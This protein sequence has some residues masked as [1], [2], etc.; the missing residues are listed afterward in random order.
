[1]L[2]EFLWSKLVKVF[3]FVINCDMEDQTP[4]N[5]HIPALCHNSSG[6]GRTGV[7]TAL[8][9]LLERMRCEG[10]I[11]LYTTAKLLRLQR[12]RMLQTEVRRFLVELDVFAPF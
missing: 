6:A 12:P 10:V 7:F 5:Q 8:S 2:T 9:H 4:C 1:M 3:V 11:D